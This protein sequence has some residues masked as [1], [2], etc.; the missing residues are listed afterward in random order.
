MD[1]SRCS[2]V[3]VL[4]PRSLCS[5]WAQPRRLS[6]MRR[7]CGHAGTSL[8]V[9]TH[10]CSN[11]RYLLILFTKQNSNREPACGPLWCA[12]TLS[13]RASFSVVCEFIITLLIMTRL[14]YTVHVTPRQT[15]SMHCSARSMFR[16]IY[17]QWT[18]RNLCIELSDFQVSRYGESFYYI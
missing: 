11:R 9:Y 17:C 12:I 10:V 14:R 7:L 2:E 13:L 1:V 3:S 4:N 6:A 5:R 16:F 15:P 8:A 18:I